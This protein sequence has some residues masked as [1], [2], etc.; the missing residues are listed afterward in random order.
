MW[1]GR[2]QH[3]LRR[4]RRGPETDGDDLPFSS[5][6]TYL[7]QW[8]RGDLDPDPEAGGLQRTCQL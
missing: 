7:C 8:L 6:A 4:C 1:R 2:K 3:R 5:L